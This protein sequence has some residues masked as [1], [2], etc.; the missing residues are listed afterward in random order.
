MTFSNYFGFGLFAAFGIWW[1]VFPHSVIAF[2]T[3]FHRGKRT[4]PQPA[5]VRV[6]GAIWIAFVIGVELFSRL[7]K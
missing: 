5:A 7:R 2:Y 4:L 3:W 6:I 1:M